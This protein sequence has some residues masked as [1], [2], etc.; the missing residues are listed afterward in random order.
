[1]DEDFIETMKQ[2]ENLD[3]LFGKLQTIEQD[4]EE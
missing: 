1:M 3:V 2:E 4:L